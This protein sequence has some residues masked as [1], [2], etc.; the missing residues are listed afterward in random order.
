MISCRV[1]LV[2]CCLEQSRYDILK[3]VVDNLE[4]QDPACLGWIEVFDNASIAP[5]TNDLLKRFKHVYRADRNVGYWSAIDWWLSSMR[6]DPPKYTYI[7]ESD[8]IHYELRALGDCVRL[9]DQHPDLGAVRLHEY[10]IANWRLYNKDAPVPGSRSNLWQSHIN[11]VT[12]EA[13]TH[14]QIEGRFWKTNFL[15]QLPALNRYHNMLWCF[16]QLRM[17]KAFTELDFQRLYHDRSQ[18][19]AIIDGGIFNCDLNPHG[20]KSITGSWTDPRRLAELGYR[21]TRTAQIFPTD[22]YTVNRV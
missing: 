8:M 22:H 11:K 18:K 16:D 14:E 2:S 17:M 5:G 10:S 12:G 6:A 7:I 20:T 13:I 15:T 9:L 1:L 19:T 3:H 4:H 21:G